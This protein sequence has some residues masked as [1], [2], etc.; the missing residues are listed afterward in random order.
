VVKPKCFD[1][2]FFDQ[3]ALVSNP[4]PVVEDF[5]APYQ[6]VAIGQLLRKRR[7]KDPGQYL[8]TGQLYQTLTSSS[9]VGKHLLQAG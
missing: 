5:V 2:A 6:S 8:F 9:E 7:L 4:C 3:K 1:G